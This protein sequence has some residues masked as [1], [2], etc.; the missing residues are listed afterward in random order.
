[1]RTAGG[2]SEGDCIGL[3]LKVG[4][5]GRDKGTLR[6]PEL[7]PLGNRQRAATIVIAATGIANKRL[8]GLRGRFLTMMRFTNAAGMRSRRSDRH[9]N[10]HDDA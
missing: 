4:R 2:G 10:R 8:I 7:R 9:G 6:G 5:K 1:M 3:D